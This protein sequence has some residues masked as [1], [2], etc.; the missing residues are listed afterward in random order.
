MMLDTA[1]R[2]HR[3]GIHGP[4]IHDQGRAGGDALRR[5]RRL[6]RCIPGLG[7]RGLRGAADSAGEIRCVDATFRTDFDGGARL[8]LQGAVA[9]GDLGD[10]EGG[11][12]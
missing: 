10:D 8:G 2:V 12:G 9:R 1:E 6:R 7:A 3:D 4:V 11:G 5:C